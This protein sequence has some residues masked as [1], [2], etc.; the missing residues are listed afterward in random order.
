M[1][2]AMPRSIEDKF[3][4]ELQKQLLGLNPVSISLCEG[5]NIEDVPSGGYNAEN[6]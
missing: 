2:L 5:K 3:Y 4:I 1:L 6:P